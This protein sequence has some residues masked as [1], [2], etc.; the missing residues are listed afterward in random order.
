M[1]LIFDSIGIKFLILFKDEITTNDFEFQENQQFLICIKAFT[2]VLIN[3][4]IIVYSSQGFKQ[5]YF[6]YLIGFKQRVEKSSLINSYKYN[7]TL[8]EHMENTIDRRLSMYKTMDIVNDCLKQYCEKGFL[9]KSEFNKFIGK[10]EGEQNEEEEVEDNLNFERDEF[11]QKV[12]EIK[13][14]IREII[15]NTWLISLFNLLYKR[16]NNYLFFNENDTDYQN[17]KDGKKVKSEIEKIIDKLLLELNYEKINKTTFVQAMA[18]LNKFKQSNSVLLQYLFIDIKEGTELEKTTKEEIDKL[19][20]ILTLQ[21]GLRKTEIINDFCKLQSNQYIILQIIA[22]IS[23][24]FVTY[25][26]YLCYFIMILN[27]IFC[28]SYLS[29]LYPLSFCFALLENPRPKYYIWNIWIGCTVALIVIKNIVQLPSF[30]IITGYKDY[31]NILERYNIGIRFFEDTFTIEYFKYIVFDGVV[32]ITLLIEKYFL[33]M[34]GLWEKR[35][36][37]IEDI[38]SGIKRVKNDTINKQYC[39]LSNSYFTR[40]FPKIRNEK[41]GKD[42][43][44]LYA[45][46]YVVIIVYFLL[47]YHEMI[48]EKFYTG[49]LLTSRQITKPLLIYIL[50][51][52][53]ILIIDRLLYLKQNKINLKFDFFLKKQDQLDIT[54][55]DY[56]DF[57]KEVTTQKKYTKKVI[58]MIYSIFNMKHLII[59]SF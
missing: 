56:E 1:K 40:L 13:T 50:I 18:S 9:M 31:V 46:F 6:E 21:E 49:N 24:L 16:Y 35:E 3:L 39:G 17:I 12:E 30:T 20:Q 11:E 8:I 4:Q 23:F 19:K 41:P 55:K 43:Y 54:D 26:D 14:M 53:S 5:F 51:Q 37:E 7:N 59:L 58:N 47:F 27:H 36:T 25:F 2:I 42:Y 32:L 15:E 57:I 52:V 48:K 29:M 45:L 38:I 33:I 44:C 28:G 10:E 34:Q 22:Q